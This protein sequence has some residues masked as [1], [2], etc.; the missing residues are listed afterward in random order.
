MKIKAGL[1]CLVMLLVSSVAWAVEYKSKMMPA[2]EVIVVNLK[3]SCMAKRI[4]GK[5]TLSNNEYEVWFTTA[6]GT[7]HRQLVKLDN[8]LWILDGEIVLTK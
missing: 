1:L 4:I 8:D 5:R 6:V 7:D 3:Q 2:D